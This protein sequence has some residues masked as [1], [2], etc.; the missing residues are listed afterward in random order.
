MGLQLLQQKGIKVGIVTSEN[1]RMVERRFEKLKLD[2]LYQGKRDGG[3]LAAAKDICDKEGISLSEVAYIGDDVNCAELLSS[4]GWAACP[5]NALPKVK[6]IPGILHLSKK[7][8]G[9][10]VRE[11]AEI[12][13]SVL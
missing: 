10:C 7:G 3:K 9:G 4:V 13:L 2:Y 12:I 6:E 8:G 1:T 5:A 11:F